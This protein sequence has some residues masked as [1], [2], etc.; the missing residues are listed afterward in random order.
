M[1]LIG[2]FPQSGYDLRKLFE[3]TAM[4]SYSSSPGAIYPALGRLQEQGLISGK[5]E[6]GD[7]LRP[8]RVFHLTADGAVALDEWLSRPV[9]REDVAKRLDELMLRFAFMHRLEAAESHGFLT[10]LAREIGAYVKELKAQLT[11]QPEEAPPHGRLAL[12]SGIEF[13]EGYARWA[14]RARREFAEA[15][16]SEKKE[17]E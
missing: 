12:E 11:L 9:G 7:S 8:K 13:Y 4:G 16:A 5:V 10:A 3:A 1:G 17:F 15:D 2:Q 6:G 14:R